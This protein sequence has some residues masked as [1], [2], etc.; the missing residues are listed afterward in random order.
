MLI[1]C[2][3]ITN[4]VGAIT[5]NGAF[6]AGGVELSG[7]ISTFSSFDVNGTFSWLSGQI[8]ILGDAANINTFTITGSTGY[9]D[10]YAPKY[11]K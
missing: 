4:I 7:M 11:L 5:V 10:G 9:L 1:T 8:Y 6:S 2:H 3:R